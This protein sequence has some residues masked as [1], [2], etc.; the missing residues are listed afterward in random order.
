MNSIVIDL[1]SNKHFIA[2]NYAQKRYFFNFEEE[3]LKKRND[4]EHKILKITQNVPEFEFAEIDKMAYAA[5]P[6]SYTGARLAFTFLDTL[7]LIFNKKFYAFSNLTALQHSYP[8]RVAVIKGSKN[9]F[10]YRYEERDHYCES[11]DQIPKGKAYV[12][13]QNDQ[14][15]L[16]N[17]VKLKFEDISKNILDLL[18]ESDNKA[19]SSNYPN[20]IKE[21]NYVKSR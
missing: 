19:L 12:V 6:G 21:L 10:F 1:T 3:S 18:L 8:D 14:L 7:S 9:D 20:Y 16:E 5:G 13:L 17:S 2:L 11:F 4:W 15:H